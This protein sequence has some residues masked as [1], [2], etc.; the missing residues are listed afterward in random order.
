METSPLGKDVPKSRP[1]Y[2]RELREQL[3]AMVRAGRSP[4]ELARDYEPSAQTI[5]NWIAQADI[6]AGVVE[7]VAATTA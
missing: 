7:C 1:P 5:R 3:I 4:E 6:D 2:P